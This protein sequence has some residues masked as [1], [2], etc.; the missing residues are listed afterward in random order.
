MCF[1]VTDKAVWNSMMVEKAFRDSMDGSFGRSISARKAIPYPEYMSMP[2]RTKYSPINHGSSLIKSTCHQVTCWSLQAIVPPLGL[3]V[4]LYSWY[5]ERS[6]V[7]VARLALV[8]GNPCCWAHVSLPFLPLW[9]LCSRAQW[10]MID[11]TEQKVVHYIQNRLF[12]P[13]DC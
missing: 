11:I 2:V 13:L 10:T 1:L 4:G 7:A 5:I 3:S 9:P 8:S 6:T 12:S